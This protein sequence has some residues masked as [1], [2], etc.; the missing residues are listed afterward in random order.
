MTESSAFSV[1]GLTGGIAS[2]KSTVAG[3][4]ED[5]GVPVID[6]DLIAREIVEPG[7]PALEEIA[8]VFGDDVLQEDDSLD[9][10]ALGSIVFGDEQARARL[11][12]ITH[13][14][15]AQR[16]AERARELGEEGHRWIIYDAALIVENGIHEW[17]DALIVVSVD[18]ATQVERLMRRDAIAREDAIARIDSQ[19]PLEDK[20]A[21]ADYIIDNNGTLEDTIAQVE[22]V[23]ARIQANIEAHG[24]AAPG[25][26][27]TGD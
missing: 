5:R 21:V 6:A 11:N 27:S 7:E 10:E 8:D 17:L 16:M 26:Y 14:R 22:R 2:G 20:V 15:V 13:P 3:M 18:R 12:A 24:S 25:D 19:L 9:R 23:H 1:V 4:F